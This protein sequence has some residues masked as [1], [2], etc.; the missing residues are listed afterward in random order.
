M[1]TF[2]YKHGMHDYYYLE[3]IL[4]PQL[5]DRIE[6]IAFTSFSCQGVEEFSID[7][8]K[9]DEILGDRSYSGADLPLSVIHEVEATVLS[10]NSR[11]TFYFPNNSEA[12]GFQKLLQ[13]EF[14]IESKVE[15]AVAQDWNE[16]WKKSYQ[17]IE[18]TSDFQI[19]PSWEKE[20]ADLDKSKK[21]VFIYPGMGFG[22][23][24]HE[25][26]FLCLKLFAQIESFLPANIQCLDFGCGSGILG[27]AAHY[28]KR[29]EFDLY[30]IDEDAL[31]NSQQNI[32]LNE[33]QEDS[34]KL[35]LPRDRKLIEKEYDLVFAN[36]LQNVLLHEQ[37]F[38]AHSIKSNGYLI[39]SGLLAGQETEVITAIESQKMGLK[40]VEVVNKGD[41]VAV[42]MQRL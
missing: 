10:E 1:T 6:S 20:N 25:T 7:E 11:K 23:G 40:L 32:E 21:H 14:G 29:G 36:I 34:F 42:L 16:E 39:L 35:L 30:D 28:F 2:R 9:V 33:M 24:G 4:P 5:E 12:F 8:P 17:S 19:T 22:T 3:T 37:Y 15:S 41:W 26:T 31:L 18:I 27:I 38:L 13:E